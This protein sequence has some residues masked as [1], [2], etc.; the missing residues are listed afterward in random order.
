MHEALGTVIRVT[1]SS[2]VVDFGVPAFKDSHPPAWAKVG[3]R[4][5]G[6]VYI[7]IDPFFYFERLKDEPGMP[8]LFREWTVH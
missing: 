4:V 3:V 2:W 7:G 5:S 6:T 1:T 8:D